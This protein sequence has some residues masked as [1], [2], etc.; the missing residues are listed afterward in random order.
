MATLLAAPA[1]SAA[2][3]SAGPQTRIIGGQPASI[4]QFPSMAM[5]VSMQEG[6]V[7]LCSGTVVSP[8]MVMT[9]AHCLIDR[10]KLALLPPES[11]SVMTGSAR[12]SDPGTVSTAQRLVV[13]PRYLPSGVGP[14][15]HDAGLV[16]LADPV[17]APAVGLAT[18]RIWEAGTPGYIVGWGK[19]EPDQSWPIP[20]MQVGR[21]VVQSE[22]YCESVLGPSFQPLSQLCMLDAP[23]FESA[24][25]SGDSG[26][27]LLIPSE[28]ELVQIGIH[29]LAPLGCLTDSPQIETRVD[30]VA[31]WV[32]GEIAAHPPL[33]E[34]RPPAPAPPSAPPPTLPPEETP[35]L[36]V[37]RAKLE[38]F[39][40]LSTNPRLRSHFRPRSGYRVFCRLR[41]ETSARCQV[42]WHRATKYYWGNVVVFSGR[43]GPQAT[44]RYRY[45]L[46]FV[47]DGCN[48][49]SDRGRCPIRV[50]KG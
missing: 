20:E 2:D 29:S 18:A 15:S 26:G 25:C 8:N 45:T 3:G 12:L 40:A 22:G 48:R 24:T 47:E 34:P 39:K 16:Q 6:S 30:A 14:G 10:T 44:L 43:D 9:A 36:T 37:A 23:S 31:G 32:Q 33:G 5:I 35:S 17:A 27:P 42:S 13:D 4:A 46:R 28:G 38:A 11:L 49:R 21:T 50:L 1:A 7:S 41:A 19:T